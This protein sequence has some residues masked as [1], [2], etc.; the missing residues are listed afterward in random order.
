MLYRYKYSLTD[1]KYMLF[2]YSAITDEFWHRILISI[3][4]RGMLL[5]KGLRSIQGLWLTQMSEVYLISV[6]DP[7]L[8]GDSR[9]TV[10]WMLAEEGAKLLTGSKR[11]CITFKFPT[12]DE[13]QWLPWKISQIR[14]KKTAPKI[15]S[16]NS[17]LLTNLLCFSS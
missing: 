8:A 4:P 15:Q 17:Q 7:S 11:S 3:S 1:I 16:V 6:V 2:Y 12:K 14:L 5:T 9:L 13:C 10:E